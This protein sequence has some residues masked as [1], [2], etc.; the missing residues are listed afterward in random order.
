MRGKIEGL[1]K[2]YQ[3]CRKKALD[4]PNEI[5]EQIYKN[6]SKIA[7]LQADKMRLENNERPVYDGGINI[8]D[9]QAEESDLGRLERF[10][11]WAKENLSGLS[12][13][14]IAVAGI[15]ATIVVRARNVI[16]QDSKAVANFAKA[17]GPLFSSVLNLIAQIL[18]L[19][20][21]RYCIS[22]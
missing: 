15:I 10:K 14:A 19:G 22:C 7:E 9:N 11:K 4:E 17:L 12:T 8:L 21:K 3:Y 5:K 13:V 16:K 2:D 6:F 1:D 20:G 18:T